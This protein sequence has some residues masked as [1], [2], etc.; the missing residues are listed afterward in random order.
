MLATIMPDIE[1]PLVS[2]AVVNWNG[3]SIICGCLDSL[4]AQSYLNREIILVDNASTDGSVELIEET[5]RGVIQILKNRTNLGFAQAVNQAVESA[6]GEW[7]ALLNSDAAADPDWLK[8]LMGEA[9]SSPV[10][11]MCAGK[12]YLANRDRLIDNMGAVISRDGLGR[13]RGRLE[14]DTGQ[15][16]RPERALCPSGCAALYRKA[17]LDEIGGFD[18]RFF[19]YAD[20]IDVGLRARLDG[21]ECQY[22][23][24][25]VV[26]HQY[27]ISAG[28]ASSMKVF[29][30]ERNR[31]WVVIKTFPL[32]Y[33]MA[34]FYFT[35]LRYFFHCY[36]TLAKK[37]GPIAQY[38]NR[39][40]LLKLVAMLLRTYGSTLRHLPCLL[41]ERKR[42]MRHRRVSSKTFGS[43][44]RTFGISARDVA[45][46]EL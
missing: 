45:F 13:G 25:A 32:R 40:V 41:A 14:Q 35:A 19:M 11:G 42:V 9:V 33:L 43:W 8:E 23:P 7:M 39:F 22:V 3:K 27:S 37:R 5:Y 36:A 20:D 15:Y 16:D 38:G 30:V 6:R 4:I 10:I 26:K 34:S 1:D 21:Y 17:M 46:K 44:L 31:L 24:S 12:T 28:A 18:A 29:L 2:I